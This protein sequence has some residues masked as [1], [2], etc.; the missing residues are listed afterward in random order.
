MIYRFRRR[1]PY[2]YFFF[3]SKISKAH[4]RDYRPVLRMD[5][6]LEI[7]NSCP[8]NRNEPRC[9]YLSS[10]FS[11]S[12][13]NSSGT[14][15]RD[16]SFCPES[17]HTRHA[18]CNTGLRSRSE[19]LSES[20]GTTPIKKRNKKPVNSRDSKLYFQY[21]IVHCIRVYSAK[22]MKLV[23]IQRTII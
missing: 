11:R 13:Q 15:S 6:E 17:R 19:S 3:G 5:S 7:G 2:F 18:N 8:E 1:A 14:F 16:R 22:T 9:R 23:D 20:R 12:V 21:E 4:V 10:S